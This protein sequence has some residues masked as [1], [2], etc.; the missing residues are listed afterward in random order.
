M[1]ASLIDMQEE[2]PDA[3]TRTVLVLVFSI[4]SLSHRSRNSRLRTLAL[5]VPLLVQLRP[6]DLELQV[7]FKMLT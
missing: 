1:V 2:L 7:P 5:S 6:T 4:A 3:T